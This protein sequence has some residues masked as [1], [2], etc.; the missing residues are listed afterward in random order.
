MATQMYYQSKITGVGLTP[1][2]KLS[3]DHV[4]SE[5]MREMYL[6]QNGKMKLEQG[7]SDPILNKYDDESTVNSTKKEDDE[8]TVASKYEAR[9]GDKSEEKDDDS[10][11]TE[12]SQ[13]MGNM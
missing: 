10:L 9:E 7:G 12:A 1:A 8:S 5:A 6:D 11:N 13:K 4:L 2:V 3:D